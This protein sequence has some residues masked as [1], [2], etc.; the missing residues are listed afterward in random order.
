[1]PRVLKNSSIDAKI[2][3]ANWQANLVD[4]NKGKPSSKNS[5]RKMKKIPT[6]FKEKLVLTIHALSLSF[7]KEESP[8]LSL[9]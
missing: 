9:N 3:F 1:M 6:F 8:H 7:P 2:S 5:S 4:A